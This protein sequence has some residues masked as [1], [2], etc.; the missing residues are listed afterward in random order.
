MS[1]RT[2]L[3]TLAALASPTLADVRLPRIFGDHMVL[4]RESEVLVWGFA[5]PG[6][7]VTVRG[8]WDDSTVTTV[9]D[10]EGDWHV[11]M[12]TGQA[13]GP[14]TLTVNDVTLSDVLL[15]EVWICSG[16]S[17]MEWHVEWCDDA[18][19]EIAAADHPRL[20]LF[21]VAKALAATPQDDV[22]GT[23][24]ACSP[25]TVGAFSATGYYFGRELLAELGD[26]PIGLVSTNWGGTVSEAWTSRETLAR[27][28]AFAPALARLDEGDDGQSLAAQQAAWWR[29][30]EQ[31]DPGFEAGWMN[32][33]VDTEP[34]TNAAVPGYFK[35]IAL[36]S[37]D[38]TV[39][40]R[41][42]VDVPAEYV[43]QEL[44]LDLGPVDDM[45]LVYL[46]GERVGATLGLGQWQSPR[47]YS[48]A[49]DVVRAGPNVLAVCAV[50]TSGAGSIGVAGGAPTS[51]RLR[52]ASSQAGEGL[53][54][55][56]TWKARAGASMGALG[57]FP[58][59]GW[60][61]ANYPTALYNAMIAPLLPYAIRGAIW[62]QG[63][64]NRAR[65]AQ[66]RRIFP[67]L[68][69][70][71]RAK[72]GRGDF[73]FYWVQ[74]APFGYGGDTGEA[75]ELREAQM[76]TQ[77]LPH[78]GMAVV[79]D[80]GNPGN[81]HPTNKQDVG[82]RLAL[83]ALA[84]NYGRDVECSG[85]V[86]AGLEV[87]GAEAR[88]TFEHAAGLTSGDSPPSHFTL[89]GSDRV[90]HSATARIEGETIVVTSDAVGA[91]VAVRYAWGAADQP[92]VKNG[93][94]LPASSFRTDDWPMVTGDGE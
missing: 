10:D 60:L 19:A 36:G 75:A 38:G 35:D 5:D 54:L 82:R 31:Q 90:F 65:A 2:L 73:P 57:A 41:R 30:L 66:Y 3:L 86:Y 59:A 29:S 27:F 39:W 13:G 50:D 67:A 44:V 52:P 9:A 80:I 48:V 58:N 93:A 94:G 17:N 87:K 76:L 56:G 74:I 47:S 46:N 89:A 53:P 6:E 4:Q 62:Y 18:Q 43:G 79:M 34:W 92:N 72:W 16:Q 78:T 81:I 14:Y 23:W 88:L 63:E 12:Q 69:E 8:G 71:W 49:A 1:L 15:G 26:V 20:R 55:E 85:P 21:T 51:L 61:H 83:W 24:T 84:K 45:D 28:D 42:T 91:P 11:H 77:S 37:F 64:S 32:A 40:Y 22:R 33:G 7:V 70:D 25:E 68:I